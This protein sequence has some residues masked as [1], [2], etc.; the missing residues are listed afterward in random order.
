MDDTE[1]SGAFERAQDEALAA[2][3]TEHIA[4]HPASAAGI[5]RMVAA[6]IVEPVAQHRLGAAALAFVRVAAD[7]SYEFDHAGYAAAIEALPMVTE[8][9]VIQAAVDVVRQRRAVFGDR[10]PQFVT[11]RLGL[12]PTDPVSSHIVREAEFALLIDPTAP[13]VLLAPDILVHV[14]TLVSG[15][16]LTHRLSETESAEGYLVL[17]GDLAGFLRYDELSF[18]DGVVEVDDPGG[19][20][21]VVWEGPEGWLDAFPPTSLLAVQVVGDELR[22][23][24]LT[25]EP[26]AP[27]ELLA[28]LRTS[29]A[30]ESEGTGD[31]EAMPVSAELLLLAMVYRDVG[32]FA[33]P[34]P[35]LSELAAAVGLQQRR[36]EFAHDPSLWVVADRVDREFRLQEDLGP[37]G[38]VDAAIEVLD[39][40]ADPDPA[41]QRRALDQ[42]QEPDL[43]VAVTE[44]LLV[45]QEPAGVAALAERLVGV[46][47]TGPRAA[48]AA[49][50]AAR[51]AE[52]DGRV[53]DAESHLRAASRFG[54]GWAFVEDQL[55][56]YEFDR[57][58]A[59]AALGRWQ[60][61][62]TP[63]DDPDMVIAAHFALA[64]G[65]EPGRNEP[66]WCGSGRKYK[67]CHLGRP[68]TATLQQRTAWLYRKALGHVERHGPDA[69]DVVAEYGAAAGLGD[70]IDA[71]FA[72]VL[73]MDVV[74]AEGGWFGA[75]LADRGPLLPPEEAELVSAWL[76]AE[77]SLYE[78]LGDGNVRDVRTDETV[79]V[80]GLGFPTG[81]LLCGLLLPDGVAHAFSQAVFEIEADERDLLLEALTDRLGFALLRGR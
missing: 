41:A 49:W 64:T 22:I 66:C 75:F 42:L 12:D 11:A 26:E 3:V 46:A 44:E 6:G 45:A 13:V 7:N 36:A 24:A 78:V 17:D 37:D 20:E 59:A 61:I 57:G 39:E 40:L 35:P 48:V 77:R 68:A 28:T 21:P 9:D 69:D 72:D 54:D 1:D 5:E 16:V 38:D 14:P 60:S 23:E 51:A 65:A 18:G 67:Q 70:D 2:F 31:D 55:A 29:Y 56:R 8:E 52:R 73:V 34:R 33:E 50:I 19:T 25:A 53:L 4:E 43:L 80:P 81:T 79:A 76:K 58:D 27:E 71:A 15:A 63:A 10:L 62:E 30:A 47:G 32:A 74:L